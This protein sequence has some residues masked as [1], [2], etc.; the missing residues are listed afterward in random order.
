MSAGGGGPRDGGPG[1]GGRTRW[2]RLSGLAAVAVGLPLVLAGC[3]GGSAAD[4]EEDRVKEHVLFVYDRST[5]LPN[6]KLELAQ[7]LTAQR[8]RGLEHG[9]R[10]AAL[11]VLQRSLAEPPR[12]W[13]QPVPEREFEDRRIP[14]D[15]VTLAR[16]RN[17]V[18]DFLVSFADTADRDHI[19]GTDLLSTFHDVGEELRAAPDHQAT[20]YVFSDMLQS[21][22]EIEM[23]RLL[24]MPARDWVE[25]A[26]AA[27]TLPDLRGLCVVVIGARV[28]TEAAQRVKAFW[29][30]YFEATGAELADRNYVLRPVEIP[31]EPCS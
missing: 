9:D 13:S 11:Q 31:R 7:D 12:R 1:G 17:D 10:V 8:V 30:E 5:S 15:S 23:E 20:M 3:R 16:F 29:T 24:R 19:N 18:R 27:G 14:D 4:F 25:E 22:P 28:D 2:A 21:T 6:H 26:A